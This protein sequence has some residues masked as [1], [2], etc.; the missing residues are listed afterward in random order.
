MPIDPERVKS[1]FLAA[2]ECD[3]PLER[4]AILD[5]K[6]SSD[7]ECRARVESMLSA[8]DRFILEAAAE[9]FSSH[10]ERGGAEVEQTI[11]APLPPE[12]SAPRDRPVPAIDGYEI[13]GESGRG[14]MGV[15]YRA[16]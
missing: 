13:L 2:A 11:Y 4:A 12:P 14:G 10:G 9:S 8:H 5:R 6:C 16:R 1:A 7:T 3:D 15:V